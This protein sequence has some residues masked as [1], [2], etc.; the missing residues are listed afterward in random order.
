MPFYS[1]FIHIYCDVSNICALCIGYLNINCAFYYLSF[2]S[3]FISKFCV[4]LSK[5]FRGN[6]NSR[7]FLSL[8]SRENESL[9]KKCFTVS[10]IMPKYGETA[11][12]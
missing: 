1:D 12:T 4:I 5:H 2:S 9:A 8:E 7:F 6:L 10:C 11:A 3:V